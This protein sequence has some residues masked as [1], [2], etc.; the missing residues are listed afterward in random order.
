MFNYK[1]SLFK[2]IFLKYMPAFLISLIIT[3]S[4][5]SQSNLQITYEASIFDSLT[6][7][8]LTNARVVLKD[9]DNEIQTEITNSKGQV[10]FNLFKEGSYTLN[11]LF[12]GYNEI[13]AHINITSEN[14][15]SSFYLQQ[16]DYTTEEIEIVA[17][18]ESTAPTEISTV[19]GAQVYNADVTHEA[20]SSRMAKIISDNLTGAVPAPT[21]EVHIRGMHGEFT[22]SIDG[23][24]VTLGVFGGLNEVVDPLVIDKIQFITG[25]FSSEYGGQLAAVI[26][27]QNRV[28]PGKFHLNFS[29]YAGSYLVFNG[30]SP[31]KKGTDVPIGKSS[32]VPGDTLGGNVGPFRTINSNGQ[33]MSF[34]G[35][36]KNLGYFLSGSREQTDRRI[37]QP[38]ATLY[39]DHGTD[40]T[41]YGKFDYPLSKN[42]FLTLNLNFANT[43]TQVPFDITKQG[44]SPDNETASNSFQTLSFT[45]VISTKANHQSRLFIGLIGRQ[46]SL[47]YTPSSVSPVNFTFAGDSTLYALSTNRKFSSV[48]LKAKYD[49]S[50]SKLVSGFAGINFSG[51]SGNSSFTSR[52]SVGNKGPSEYDT[53]KGSDF[54]VFTNVHLNPL[55]YI[56]F[57]I[58]VRYDQH[59][60]PDTTLQKQ[61]SPRVKMSFMIDKNNSGYLYYGRFFMPTNIEALRSLA[62]NISQNGSATL[63]EKDNFYEAAF[64]HQFSFG[65]E[66]KLDGYY[67]YSSPGL[68]DQT[69]GSSAIKTPVNIQFVRTTGVELSLSYSHK[70]IPISTFLNTALIHAYGSGLITGG[71]L[72]IDNAGTATDL[73][74][75]QRLTISS[76]LNYHPKKWF[77]ELTGSYGSG[78]TNGN[79]YKVPSKTGLFN[80]NSSAHVSPWVLFNI[81]A[82]YTFSLKKGVTV[83]PSI[84]INNILDSSYLLKGAFFSSASYGER[85]NVILKL[86]LHI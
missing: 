52:D 31:F 1:H 41:L 24:P 17:E 30:T 20:P 18:R 13:N 79:P 69:I 34:S 51:T 83:Q 35:H 12:P 5:F 68:D 44:Y 48:G 84:Y 2:H 71:F 33:S 61:F 32:N 45:H 66:A 14:N 73:D 74:H 8:P 77:V 15:T 28:P 85:R 10:K 39:N 26:D 11:I 36:L 80:F 72:P 49:I 42:D 19:T 62:S 40:Y 21:G 6:S 53:Y 37:D 67:R 47:T 78:L 57:D 55:N 7:N 3:G 16:K 43:N 54:G 22:Y 46:G 56:N 70:K 82:G 65:L 64:I 9:G 50:F 25:G 58:G 23:M 86:E 60:S 27:V 75:D 81:G 38:V 4:L 59:I 76:G 63:P 29:S